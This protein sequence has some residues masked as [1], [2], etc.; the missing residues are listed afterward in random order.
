MQ[1]LIQALDYRVALLKAVHAELWRLQHEAEL[2]ARRV[3]SQAAI[4][5]LKAVR[6][7]PEAIP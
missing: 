4:E 3:L 2:E 1:Q 5:A 7:A 6:V